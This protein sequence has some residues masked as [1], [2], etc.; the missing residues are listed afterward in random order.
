MTNDLP[1]FKRRALETRKTNLIEVYDAVSRQLDTA[2]ESGQRVRLERQ[3]E[4]LEGQMAEIDAQL[5]EDQPLQPASESEKAA[6]GTPIP[7]SIEMYGKGN[8][9]AV[10]VG[11]NRY[12]DAA[13]PTLQVCVKD[14]EATYNQLI[15]GGFDAARIHLLTD[16]T[17][18]L[19]TRAEIL[20][21]LEQAAAAAQR[22]DLILFYYSGHGDVSK[23]TSYLV[24]Q[25]G[26]MAALKRTAVALADLVEILQESEARTKVIILD[27]CHSG[28]NFEGKGP[29]TMPPDFIE[30]VF[31]QA[32]GQVILASCEQGQFSYE[33]QAQERSVFT[34]FLLEALQGGADLD[35]KGFVT[36]QDVNRHVTNGVRTWAFKHKRAQTPTLQGKMAGDI[37]LVKRTG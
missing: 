6:F 29:K 1:D 10:L 33:W 14:V 24:G 3:L 19:P 15:A 31:E 32:K 12:L 27:A 8:R 2:L 28:A 30:R 4:D 18:T 23:D 26:K 9:W 5:G 34:H 25:D 13:Y 21:S 11:V 7:T 37:V 17:E 20:T 35:E 22:D 36:V 16:N